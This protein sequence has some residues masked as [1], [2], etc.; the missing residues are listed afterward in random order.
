MRTPLPSASLRWSWCDHAGSRADNND[1]YLLSTE[2]DEKVARLHISALV[3]A[4]KQIVRIRA[5]VPLHLQRSTATHIV[6]HTR[7]VACYHSQV[8]LHTPRSR[9]VGP[10]RCDLAPLTTSFGTVG[11]WE[12]QHLAM[13][14]PCPEGEA[15]A[16]SR[17]W[18]H[19]THF[20]W[21]PRAAPTFHPPST[22]RHR[23][24]RAARANHLVQHRCC[25]LAEVV[26][27]N[28]RNEARSTFH[29]RSCGGNG[30]V[31]YLALWAYVGAR[32]G[33]H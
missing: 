23:A 2:L 4:L 18:I 31:M 9:G 28:C 20:L 15:W 29:D 33:L 25:I 7:R 3:E 30:G 22:L 26:F 10:S 19:G 17:N 21:D 14:A 32:L 12:R 1:V 8:H 5:R 16:A 24:H 6:T 27:G 13:A 11:Q